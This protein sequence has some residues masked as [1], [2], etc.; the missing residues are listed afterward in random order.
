M[1]SQVLGFA[2]VECGK[3]TEAKIT[4]LKEE[5]VTHSYQKEAAHYAM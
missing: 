2:P 5:L 3:M 4:V 1:S